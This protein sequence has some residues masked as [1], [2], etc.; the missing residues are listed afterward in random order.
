MK[1]QF[2]YSHFHSSTP[3]MLRFYAGKHLALHR[4]LRTWQPAQRTG[5]SLA[6]EP[7]CPNFKCGASHLTCR[8]DCRQ[9]ARHRLLRI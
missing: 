8:D 2:L 5:C 1:L 6:A 3:D 4:V 9:A 7:G